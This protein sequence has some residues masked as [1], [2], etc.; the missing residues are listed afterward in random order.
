MPSPPSTTFAKSF[1]ISPS[2]GLLHRVTAVKQIRASH[3]TRLSSGDWNRTRQ[4]P[5]SVG[6]N[7]SVGGWVS[8]SSPS[9]RP[10][11]ADR[12]ARGKRRLQRML[13]ASD[14]GGSAG[15]FN[16]LETAA[17]GGFKTG[18]TTT[19][20]PSAPRGWNARLDAHWVEFLEKVR[21]L[22]PK[23]R[24]AVLCER[25]KNDATVLSG[26]TAEL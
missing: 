21:R 15:F 25:V 18:T 3:L 20:P 22:P 19:S 14:G 1:E 8:F 17:G 26:L 9:S 24:E 10:E 5:P 13:R 7:S 12:G 2:Q 11:T 4:A 23:V 16:T 6:V